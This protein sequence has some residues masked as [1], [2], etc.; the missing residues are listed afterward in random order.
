MRYFRTL[1]NEKG[2]SLDTVLEVEGKEW[3]LNMIPVEVVV[4]FME[5]RD[6]ATQKKM[7]D[8][9]IKIDFQNGDVMHFIKY[10]AGFLAK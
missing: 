7:R 1:L 2:I 4:E 6:N 3:G 8:T 5:G 9:L 10:I